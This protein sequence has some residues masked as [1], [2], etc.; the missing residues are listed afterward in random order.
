MHNA[1]MR[2]AQKLLCLPRLLC[3]TFNHY[4][5]F[6]QNRTTFPH[7]DARSALNDTRP[8]LR[9]AGRGTVS[10]SSILCTKV[11]TMQ[12]ECYGLYLSFSH[13]SVMGKPREKGEIDSKTINE[14]IDYL[15]ISGTL[16]DINQ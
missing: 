8:G 2:S 1:R 15:M 16:L 6:L 14:Q 4:I 9:M 13:F 7:I 3:F 12:T 10:C 11:K 5:C